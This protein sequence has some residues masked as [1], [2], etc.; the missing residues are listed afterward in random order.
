[1]VD[2]SFIVSLYVSDL[3]NVTISTRTRTALV[4]ITLITVQYEYGY[5]PYRDG[6]TH[7]GTT[8]HDRTMSVDAL[9]RPDTRSSAWR[10]FFDN[11]GQI[12]TRT[13]QGGLLLVVAGCLMSIINSFIVTQHHP[14]THSSIV[15]KGH[16]I[17]VES[18]PPPGGT[19]RGN[20]DGMN[21]ALR[22]TG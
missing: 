2:F 8:W 19:A 5:V 15:N 12:E 3:P 22:M 13:K 14:T 20:L 1:M 11:I 17:I 16:V 18:A 6:A 7:Q 10:C 4:R 21:G 9:G